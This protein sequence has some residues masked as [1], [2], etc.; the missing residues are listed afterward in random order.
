MTPECSTLRELRRAA[1]RCTETAAAHCAAET[2]DHRRAREILAVVAEHCDTVATVFVTD[3]TL[4]DEEQVNPSLFRGVDLFIE[5]VRQLRRCVI[6]ACSDVDLERF[7]RDARWEE[8]AALLV[9]IEHY[10]KIIPQTMPRGDHATTA[11]S[12]AISR[13]RLAAQTDALAQAAND[14]HAACGAARLRLP[15]VDPTVCELSEFARRLDELAERLH[16]E[17][18]EH[19]IQ[20]WQAYELE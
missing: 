11:G 14:L 12:R 15:T 16:A 18:R 13:R 19:T 8:A 9:R 5:L 2:V 20:L 10:T 7:P 6:W 17:H 1:R 4:A 3:P